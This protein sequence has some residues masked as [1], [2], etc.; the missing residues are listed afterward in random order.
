MI[1]TSFVQ[2]VIQA[3]LPQILGHREQPFLLSNV[4]RVSWTRL[5]VDGNSVWGEMVDLSKLSWYM[6]FS[7]CKV[8]AGLAVVEIGLSAGEASLA[9]VK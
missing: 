7:L 8:V 1:L 6:I 2:H 9:G 5:F 4:V 3:R